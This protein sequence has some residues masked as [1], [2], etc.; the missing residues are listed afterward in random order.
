SAEAVRAMAAECR[1]RFGADYGLAVSRFP[2]FDPAAPEPKPMFVGL[3]DADGVQVT[4]FPHAGHPATLKVFSA[5][6]A[7][8]VARLAMLEA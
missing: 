6:R 4:S 3:A 8:N 5:N 7:L 1:H 2:E